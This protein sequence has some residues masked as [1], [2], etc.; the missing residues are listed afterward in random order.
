MKLSKKLVLRLRLQTYVLEWRNK[1]S[2][3][4]EKTKVTF[5]K[6]LHLIAQVITVLHFEKNKAQPS[7]WKERHSVLIRANADTS[8]EQQYKKR[9]KEQNFWSQTL[10][11]QFFVV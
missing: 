1:I 7:T 10:S 5:V 8:E 4:I 3:K 6:S 9:I 11:Y 2:T